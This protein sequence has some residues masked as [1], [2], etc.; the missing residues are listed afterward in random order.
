MEACAYVAVIPS[1]DNIRKTSVFV[2]L[3]LVL[4]FMLMLLSSLVLCLCLYTIKN[5][6]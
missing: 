6:P 1:E 5:E 3:M 2:F 4:K